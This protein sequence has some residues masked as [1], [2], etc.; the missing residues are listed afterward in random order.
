MR[1]MMKWVQ[2]LF[3]VINARHIEPSP[4]SFIG[5][6]WE[7]MLPITDYHPVLLSLRRLNCYRKH[8]H[9]AYFSGIIK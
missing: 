7:I 4:R 2:L 9:H 1:K 6:M 8:N 5:S 3:A